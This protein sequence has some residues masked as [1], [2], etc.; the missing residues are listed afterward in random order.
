MEWNW[1]KYASE[2]SLFSALIAALLVAAVAGLWR[3]YRNSRDGKRIYEYLKHSASETGYVFRSTEA[4]SAHTKMP[5]GRV[6]DLCAKHPKIKRNEKEKQSWRLA[7][8]E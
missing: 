8:K 1:A 7:D 4:I 5:E 2:N 3:L 6:A